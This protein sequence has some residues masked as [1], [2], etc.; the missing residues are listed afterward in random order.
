MEIVL[1]NVN[2]PYKR[3]NSTLFSKLRLCL[4]FLKNNKLKVICVKEAYFGEAYSASLQLHQ[5]VS[6]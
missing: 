3:V 1:I 6:A 4:L 2:F 5:G